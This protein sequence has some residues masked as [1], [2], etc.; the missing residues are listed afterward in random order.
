MNEKVSV[1]VPVY[2]VEA[3][4][5]ECVRSI[6]NQTYTNLEIILVDDG[7][8]DNCGAMCDA[9]AEK[10]SRIK[11]IHQEN[12]GISAAR[13]AG[14]NAATSQ[15]IVFV[16][17][18][19]VVSVHMVE[20]L[21][22]ENPQK[23]CLPIVTYLDFTG[24]P[25]GDSGVYTCKYI[26]GRN[27]LATRPGYYCW[28]VLYNREVIKRANLTFDPKLNLLEDEG[29]NAVYLLFVRRILHVA[30]PMYYYRH[31]PE[32]LT[33]RISDRRKLAYAWRNVQLSVMAWF[34][35]NDPEGAHKKECRAFFRHCQNKMFYEYV[36]TGS[37]FADYQ[38]CDAEMTPEVDRLLT[39]LFPAEYTFSKYLPR[40]Y[41]GC[42]SGLMK[43]RNKL[44][45][46]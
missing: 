29:W 17:S 42:Y 44:A 34:A 28:G 32:S 45:G 26:E 46:R 30:E 16:D 8:P 39:R 5:D 27:W 19:D 41:F 10:D 37:G 12:G 18:D 7:S 13:N 31:Y 38:N 36:R 22:R 35:A 33:G 2:K 3:Y 43:L 24:D 40:L 4:L 25:P 1:I 20:S 6:V 14:L 11:V 9:W 23:D 21:V 15:W